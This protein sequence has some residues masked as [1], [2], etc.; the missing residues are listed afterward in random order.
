MKKIIQFKE[1]EVNKI[2]DL[3]KSSASFLIFEYQGIDA[4]DMTAVRKEMLKSDANL[5]IIKNN[6]LNRA[7]KKVGFQEFGELVGPNAIAFGNSDEIAPL[8]I[9]ND[10]SKTNDCIKF[11][12]SVIDNKFIDA[13]KTI[14]ISK[15]P[16]REGL[17]SMLLSCLTAPIRGFLYA[18]KA[19]E[20]TK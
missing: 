16:N 6:I 18:L 13:E 4:P 12:G 19:I 8:K 14:A 15:L 20:E 2:S 7:L 3:M 10:L 9:I 17:Y 5:H 11:K 1:S